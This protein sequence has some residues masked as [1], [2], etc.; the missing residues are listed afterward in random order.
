MFYICLKSREKLTEK[1]LRIAL[2]LLLGFF[3][4]GRQAEAFSLDSNCQPDGPLQ[5]VKEWW[6]P[7]GFWSN[8]VSELIKNIR[9]LDKFQ[10]TRLIDLEKEKALTQIDKQREAVEMAA[11]RKQNEVMGGE[12]AAIA[13][14]SQA[15]IINESNELFERTTREI[16]TKHELIEAKFY[17]DMIAL[18]LKCLG[19]A[20]IKAAEALKK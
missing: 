17:E 19:I 9:E 16:Q 15:A 13:W 6:N 20:K 5:K 2:L 8:E 1:P 7:D 11:I 18:R 3:S 12:Q 14:D 10:K 4:F